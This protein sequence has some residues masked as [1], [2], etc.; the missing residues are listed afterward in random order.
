MV[1]SLAQYL[2]KYSIKVNSSSCCPLCLEWPFLILTLYLAKIVPSFLKFGSWQLACANP[3]PSLP[4]PVRTDP[5][6]LMFPLCPMGF[7]QSSVDKESG[8]NAGDPGSIPGLG[9]SSGEGIDYPLQYSWTS[10]VAQLVENLPTMREAWVW[11]L[12]WEDPLEK[13]KATHSS[14]L[15]I[16]SLQR[17]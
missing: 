4:S 7:P 1:E 3:L 9:R 2:L 5:P 12:G 17:L 13:G 10:F 11:S 6:I 8:Y 16:Q 15:A 14:I